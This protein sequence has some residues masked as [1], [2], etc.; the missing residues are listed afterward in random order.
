MKD[1]KTPY[2]FELIGSTES[3][4]ALQARWAKIVCQQDKLPLFSSWEWLT[5]WWNAFSQPNDQLAIVLVERYGEL[6]A[7][8]P[9]FVRRSRYYGLPRRILRFIGEGNSDRSDILVRDPDTAFYQGVLDFLHDNVDW[10]VASLREVPEN[11]QLIAWASNVEMARVEK[12]SDCPFITFEPGLTPEVFRQ[13]LSRKLRREFSNVTNRMK[14]LGEYRFH[15]QLLTHPDDPVLNRIR[16]IELKSAKAKKNINLVFSPNENFKFQQ[17]LLQSLS[18]SVQRLLTVLEVN[19]V[20]VSYL[21]GFIAGNTYHAYNMAFL[22]EYAS[23][24]TGKLTLQEAIEEAIRMHLN[25]FD[26]LRGNSYIKSK[27]SNTARSQVHLTFFR[28]GLINKI[29]ALLIFKL[30]PHLKL[31]RQWLKKQAFRIYRKDNCP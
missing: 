15:H 16:D 30:R 11:S 4:M 9:F 20:I 8:A 29:H 24:S 1:S 12:D 17:S 22:P 23:L 5:A 13:S 7:I 3:F 19:G 28:D 2:Q 21:Y 18:G 6:F 31:L 26:F 25:E 14:K 27:W 10:D